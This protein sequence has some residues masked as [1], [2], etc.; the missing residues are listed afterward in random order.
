MRRIESQLEHGRLVPDTEKFALKSPDRFKEKLWDMIKAEP[1]KPANH[2]AAELHD[3]I[4]Y[5][6]LFEPGRYVDGVRDATSLIES[7]D[8]EF[9]VRKNT[10]PN[11]EY[12][13]INT[14]WADPVSGVRFE[15]QFHTDESWQA[16][17]QTHDSYEK[18]TDPATPPAQRERLRDYQREVSSGVASPHGCEAITNYRKEG[19]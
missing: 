15:I 12:K 18:I 11:A 4:R 5:T 17:Q 7:R 16:K 1:D 8:F 13:G 2:H 19:W 14:R 10:W 6:F 3:G 9:G